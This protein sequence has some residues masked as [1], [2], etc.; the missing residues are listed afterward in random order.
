MAQLG[1]L[2]RIGRRFIGEATH[3]LLSLPIVVLMP[4]GSCNCR[5][6]MCDIWKQNDAGLELSTEL[7]EAQLASVAA[8]GVERVV[9]SGG[10][11][12]MH[13]NL[14]ALF[15]ALTRSGAKI[16]LLSTGLLL[17]A[18]ADA[19]VRFCDELIVSLDGSPEVHDAIRRVPRAFEK[20]RH[21]IA[22]LRERGPMRISGRCVLQ[23]GN[24]A[25]L[26]E[27]ID[28]AHTL[29]LD[30]ISFLAADVSTDAFNR[31]ET[32][33]AERSTEVA[34]ER[35]EVEAFRA[36]VERTITTHAADFAQGFV[37]ESP[38]KLRRLPR[39]YGALLGL[40]P[41]PEVRCNAPWVS[42]VV[43]ADGTVRPCFF[44]APIGNVRHE[45]LGAILASDRAVRFRAGLDVAT[46]P[47]C[48]RCVCS[49][50]LPATKSPA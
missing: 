36:I 11:A 12:L 4:H 50:N 30:R 18:R 3:H 14:E 25:D 31:P 27:I 45:E 40:E 34:L 24:F 15:E 41:F 6:V 48:R 23:R 38:D 49:L 20:M 35:A 17:A 42:T 1:D 37:A 9:L 29:G 26:P 16:T 7:V 8:L 5:C 39:Y 32:W 2:V 44:H 43:E 10:E 47:I 21:G 19:I 22:A 33:D 46:D 13:K 28:A